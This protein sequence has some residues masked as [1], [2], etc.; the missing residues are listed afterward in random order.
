MN[1]IIEPEV[2]IYF[3]KYN[4]YKLFLTGTRPFVC[5]VPGQAFSLFSTALLIGCLN[6]I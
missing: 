4:F 3:Y 6:K 2:F 1:D 5:R